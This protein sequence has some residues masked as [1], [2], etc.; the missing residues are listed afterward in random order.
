MFF[1]SGIP[2]ENAGQKATPILAVIRFLKA[3]GL[4]H[5]NAIW[6]KKPT[7]EHK[8]SHISLKGKNT[9]KLI[10]LSFIML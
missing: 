3:S 8:L 7:E 2:Q 5:S 6:G 10:K 9:D 1:L 4:S